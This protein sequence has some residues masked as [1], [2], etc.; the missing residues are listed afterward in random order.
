MALNPISFMEQVVSDFL[1]YQLESY[2]VADS[3][4]QAQMRVLL[5][6]E[7]SSAERERHACAI[8]GDTEFERQFGGNAPA[9]SRGSIPHGTAQTM[10]NGPMQ[11]SRQ[12]K[13][14][15]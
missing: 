11:T 13:L 2:P 10:T 6:F 5:R 4:L 1:R 3:D 7:E 9:T 14:F 12:G 8:L 15:E